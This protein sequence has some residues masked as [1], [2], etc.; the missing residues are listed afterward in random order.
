VVYWYVWR[1]LPERSG[2]IEA[3]AAGATVNSI[4]IGGRHI[5]A[6]A[7]GC[8]F[9]PGYVKAQ[10]RL[11]RWTHSADTRAASIAEIL[12]RACGDDDE[13]RKCGCGA[14][15]VGYV[16]MDGQADGR[17][18]AAYTSGVTQSSPPT[19]RSSLGI[20]LLKD[21]RGR[22]AWSIVDV[23]LHICT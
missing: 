13:A 18:F 5:R 7:S 2:T 9:P 3:L 23:V 17:H 4:H 15:G 10:D 6:P 11:G 16:T 21:Q 8:L 14:C 1:P 20:P 22:G 19:E 12:G